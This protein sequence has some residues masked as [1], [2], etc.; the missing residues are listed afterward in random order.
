MNENHAFCHRA[1]MLYPMNI[2]SHLPCEGSCYACDKAFFTQ[3]QHLHSNV[4]LQA[5]EVCFAE[6]LQLAGS[7]KLQVTK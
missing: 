6:Q 5:S 1:G 3:H 4:Y 2:Q 7:A